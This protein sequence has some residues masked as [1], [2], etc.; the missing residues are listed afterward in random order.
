MDALQ[1]Q[2]VVKHKQH[3]VEEQQQEDAIACCLC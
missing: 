2:D 1:V 3:N